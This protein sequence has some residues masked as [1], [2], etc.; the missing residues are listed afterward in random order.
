MLPVL[1]FQ[2]SEDELVPPSMAEA[3]RDLLTSHGYDVTYREF[4]GGHRVPPELLVSVTDWI[5]D[6]SS[7]N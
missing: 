5:Q 1:I 7:G 6:R 2:G 3:T 4:V